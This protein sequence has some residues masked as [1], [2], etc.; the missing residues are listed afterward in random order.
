MALFD[1]ELID[2]HAVE[3]L[4]GNAPVGSAQLGFMDLLDE[5]PTYSPR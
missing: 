5:I 2:S 1:A 3:I 4:E